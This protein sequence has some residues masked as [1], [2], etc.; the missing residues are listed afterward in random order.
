MEPDSPRTAP[1]GARGTAG[2]KSQST[3]TFPFVNFI[4]WQYSCIVKTSITTDTSGLVGEL[5]ASVACVCVCVCVHARACVFGVW[6]CGWVGV[7]VHVWMCACVD[8]RASEDEWGHHQRSAVAAPSVA[9][10]S[11]GAV[12]RNTC[13]H[14]AASQCIISPATVNITSVTETEGESRCAVSGLLH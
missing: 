12:R 8:E 5:G 1:V 9:D 2:Q 13:V 3:S 10:V 7:C 11:G 4:L 14:N 6:V